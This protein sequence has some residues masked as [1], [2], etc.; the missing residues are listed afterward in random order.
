[1]LNPDMFAKRLA[2][3][4]PANSSRPGPS[5]SGCCAAMVAR[6]RQGAV[7]CVSGQRGWNRRHRT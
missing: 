5:R 4:M 2:S 3:H 7:L 1:M 6:Q